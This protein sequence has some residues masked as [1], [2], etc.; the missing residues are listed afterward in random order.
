MLVVFAA[1]SPV[2]R[3]EFVNFDDDVAL[4]ENPHYRGLS[5]THVRWMF[6]TLHLGPY[7][8]LSWLTHAAV[9]SG[10][11][12]NPAAYH[13]TNLLIHAANAVLFY[14]VVVTLLP[15]L[16]PRCVW[17]YPGAALVG[18]LLFA[19]HP[20]RVEPVAWATERREVL[21]GF[22]VLLTVLAYLRM[23]KTAARAWWRWYVVS[24]AC[25]A[26]SLLSKAMGMTLPIV[27]LALDAYPLRRLVS[28]A[29]WTAVVAEKI[30]YIVLSVGAATVAFAGQ[31]AQ[32][33][34]SL[35]EHGVLQRSAQAAYGLCFYLWKTV[36]PLQ[37]SPLY[38]ME[39]PLDPAE[40]RY[41]LSIV[42]V[43]AATA[44]VYRLRRR[45][46]GLLL[47]W[48]C[49]V[50]A[51]SPVLG[52]AQTGAQIAAD[53]YTYL[54]CMPWAGLAAVG[55]CRLW[56]AAEER[57]IGRGTRAAVA[58][59]LAMAVAGLAVGTYR[60]TR[61]WH[62]SDTLW[63]HALRIQPS[64]SIAHNNRGTVRQR[65]GDLDGALADYD[66]AIAVSPD[67]AKAYNN[68]GTARL[69]KGDVSGAL[70]D[71]DRALALNPSYTDAY[72]NRGR[73]REAKRD[74]DGALADYDAALRLDPQHVIAH[75]NR[76]NVYYAQGDLDR[77]IA[78][79][80]SA[81]GL[82]PLQTEAYANRAG[83][84]RAK[85]DAEGALADYA[86]ALHL[87]PRYAPAYTGRG[88][89]H[90]ARGELEAAVADYA[91]ALRVNPRD[92]T[93]LARRANA[94][95]MRGD[96]DGALSDLNAALR[97][98]PSEPSLYNNRGAAR[99][100]S[101]DLEGAVADYTHA[102]RL[103]AP[104]TSHRAAFEAN[105]AAARQEL[106]QRPARGTGTATDDASGP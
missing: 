70:A 64:N 59:V 17:T 21:G 60:Q 58:A 50:V 87:D 98:N 67:Y 71:C 24:V 68:R 1:F 79:Y 44:G 73:A 92:V 46:P 42:A 36:V 20:L 52:F 55:I 7:Q 76:G 25:F 89:I 83:A 77:A 103:S 49:Y 66:R 15:R 39:R 69:A 96:V 43:M 54:P 2:V 48:T 22:F 34:L 72:V 41:V 85:G 10:W 53:R 6:T 102:V 37:L 38:Q 47:A 106:A 35:A 19:V 28:R 63:S 65:R 95:L 80:T 57:R 93:A 105:L 13:L 88:G 99:Q 97:V 101:G 33:M 86:A 75:N 51:V 4:V 45:L 31:R 84:R 11:G 100:R 62:D 91:A 61:V 78:D 56:S 104:E 30:P 40:M 9:Y 14:L 82:N 74:L 29:G 16:E 81:I 23:Q 32:P 94:R 90:E 5:W 27:L 18:A 8:P 3:N 26:L 12:L